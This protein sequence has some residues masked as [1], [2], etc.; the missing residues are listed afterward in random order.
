MKNS[1][2]KFE[3]LDLDK[4]EKIGKKLILKILILIFI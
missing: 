2:L 1:V 3:I 4:N